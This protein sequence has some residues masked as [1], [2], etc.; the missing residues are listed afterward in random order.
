MLAPLV[1]LTA[2][3]PQKIILQGITDAQSAYFTPPDGV[4]DLLEEVTDGV[5]SYRLGFERNLVIDTPDGWVIVD[6]FSE[7]F[8]EGLHAALKKQAPDKR[9]KALIYSHYHLDHITGGAVLEPEEVVAP[10]IVRSYWADLDVSEVLP[11][12]HW[13]NGDGQLAYGGVAIDAVYLGRSHTDTLY[14]F[15]V[16][17]KGVLF[18]PDSA[19]VRMIPP[20]GLP[21]TYAPGHIR[22]LDRM[23]SLSFEHWVPSHGWD[24]GTPEQLREFRDM[25][26]YTREICDAQVRRHGLFPDGE[27]RAQMLFETL[28]PFEERYGDWYGFD[29]QAVP[30]LGRHFVGVGIG[31]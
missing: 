2:C 13:W 10:S 14:A 26:V 18:T 8:A 21:Q 9:V 24:L 7:E 22:A 4:D 31:Y 29:A 1:S 12:T 30:W 6:C 17:S 27:T 23:L 19:F 11:P 15:H 20:G 5:Y 3:D 16:P 25:V 28:E